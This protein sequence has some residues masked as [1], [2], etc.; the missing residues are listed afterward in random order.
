M[1][2]PLALSSNATS[3]GTTGT[4]AFESLD[5][6][7]VSA[8][9]MGFTSTDNYPANA[10]PGVAPGRMTGHTGET[11][12]YGQKRGPAPKTTAALQIG[13]ENMPDP[14]VEMVDDDGDEDADSLRGKSKF[15][16]ASNVDDDD[17]DA[18]S[19]HE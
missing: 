15:G 5:P 19:A 1:R 4:A 11:Y 12:T 14:N 16:A 18:E 8:F 2:K 9:G 10:P 7:D 6:D 3:T 13:R 17:M